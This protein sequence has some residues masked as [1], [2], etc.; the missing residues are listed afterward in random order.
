[1]LNHENLG[2]D[3]LSSQTSWQIVNNYVDEY[4]GCRPCEGFT[5]E[6]RNE[7]PKLLGSEKITSQK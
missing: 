4:H 5:T 3:T 1:M 2:A 7:R 6:K